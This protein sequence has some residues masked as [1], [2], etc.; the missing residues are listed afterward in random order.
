MESQK[1]FSYRAVIEASPGH[2]IGS[3]HGGKKYTQ[4]DITRRST[5]CHE[6]LGPYLETKLTVAAPASMDCTE[7]KYSIYS[8]L[9]SDLIPTYK[10]ELLNEELLVNVPDAV[11]KTHLCDSTVLASGT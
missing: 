4:P 7:N 10:V 11:R 2:T 6:D 3:V 8:K 9:Y 5:C 1:P